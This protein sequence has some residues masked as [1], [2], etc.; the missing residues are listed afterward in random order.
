MLNINA[1]KTNKG[2]Y[3]SPSMPNRQSWQTPVIPDNYLFD[4]VKPEPSFHR[5]WVFIKN[6]PTKITHLEYQPN[7]NYRYILKDDSLASDKIPLE[8][9]RDDVG[10]E[11]DCE[12]KI[13]W[14]PELAM[15]RSLYELVSDEQPPKE[16]M[17]EFTFTVLF[18]I[19]EI[20]PPQ[21]FKYPTSRT[22]IF[23]GKIDESKITNRD[24]QH[25]ELDRIIFPSLLI[26]ETPCK[27]SS[28]DTYKIIRE[29]VNTHINSTFAVVTSNYDF[30]FEVA[31]RIPLAKPYN[32]RYEH[33][34]RG[35]RR[36]IVETRLVKDKQVKFFEMTHTKSNY[37]GYTPIQGF[38]G[39]N[40]VDLK[41]QIDNYLEELIFAINEPV[42]ECPGCNGQGVIINELKIERDK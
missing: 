35:R 28:E 42:T 37:Q 40:E 1:I 30:C 25:Q 2:Y 11:T 32:Q 36:P 17:E 41:E 12:G 33:T 4:G 23:G 7:T 6:I 24:I 39:K 20:L 13:I 31:K 3:I 22:G 38:E 19:G 34:P 21:E 9:K 26:H 14:K 10:N 15:Y 29:Y 5:E 18:E 8:I 27:L 16:V